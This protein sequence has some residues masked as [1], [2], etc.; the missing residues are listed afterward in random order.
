MPSSS[1]CSEVEAGCKR[2]R[3]LGGRKL[4]SF[5]SHSA[6]PTG[7][8]NK[9]PCQGQE[10]SA[11]TSQFRPIA[12][13][14]AHSCPKMSKPEKGVASSSQGARLGKRDSYCFWKGAMATFKMDREPTGVSDLRLKSLRSGFQVLAL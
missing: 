12:Q 4:S 11:V 3:F 2:S 6:L 13:I 8:T 5:L 10:A 1:V 9:E 7:T 14:Q